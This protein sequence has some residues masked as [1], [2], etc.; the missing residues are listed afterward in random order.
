MAP[1]TRS[2]TILAV[3]STLLAALLTGCVPGTATPTAAPT[4]SPTDPG[5]PSPS[6]TETDDPGSMVI[7]CETI[8]SPET[9][10]TFEASGLTLFPPEEF[11]AKN[12][13]EGHPGPYALMDANGGV[14]CPWHANQEVI[15][16]YGYSPLS[17]DQV[18][19]AVALIG[20]GNANT[21]S[22][23]EDGTLY[24]SQTE[25]NP[26]GLFFITEGSWYVGSS[27]ELIDEMRSIVP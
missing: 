5:S 8:L 17:A 25:G 13:A 18:E 9:R 20:E 21:E 19:E 3:S 26:F 11:Y 27:I 4:T 22:P 1:I 10:A 12:E 23:Y 14:V 6:P 24:T 16:A 2:A 15:V 7:D